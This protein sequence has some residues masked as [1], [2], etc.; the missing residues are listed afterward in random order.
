MC[1][2]MNANIDE[3]NQ[4]RSKKKR[5][6]YHIHWKNEYLKCQFLPI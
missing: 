6:L 3:K 4:G 2:R 5:E 1:P